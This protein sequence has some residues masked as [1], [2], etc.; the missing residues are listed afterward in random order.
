[1]GHALGG[2]ASPES[3]IPLPTR[4]VRLWLPFK[5]GALEPHKEESGH[6]INLSSNPR[7]SRKT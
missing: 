5:L 2:Y 3:N 4:Q 7:Q 6:I 1:M